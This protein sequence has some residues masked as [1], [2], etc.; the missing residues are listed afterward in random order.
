MNNWLGYTDAV[1]NITIEVDGEQKLSVAAKSKWLDDEDDHQRYIENW[2]GVLLGVMGKEGDFLSTL[3]FK[4]LK[5][6]GSKAEIIS[7][8]FDED[9][10][11]WNKKKKGISE[12]SLLT[13][14]YI[15]SSP[16]GW[17]NGTYNFGQS[18]SRTQSTNIEHTETFS[19][20]GDTSLTV[21]LDVEIPLLVDEKTQ[22]STDVSYQWTTSDT[23]STT[24][25][26]TVTFDSSQG[27]VHFLL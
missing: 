8:Q 1:G 19:R 14:W 27:C 23:T 26:Y 21:S 9:L 10:D 3:E 17:G 5:Q 16:K 25:S 11:T 18:L 4:F 6:T 15:N 20:G 2:S 22:L 24:N 13:G 12:Q 7:I